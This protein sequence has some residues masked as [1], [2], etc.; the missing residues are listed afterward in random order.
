MQEIIKIDYP[1]K[2]SLKNLFDSYNCELNN[3]NSFVADYKRNVYE[4]FKSQ[5]F[6]TLKDEG[7]RY[8]NIS[9]LVNL[10]LSFPDYKTHDGDIYYQND[11]LNIDSYKIIFYNGKYL[12]RFSTIEELIK[13]NLIVFSSIAEELKNPSDEFKKYFASL[14]DNTRIFNSINSIFFEDGY[15]IKIKEGV[16][17]QKPILAIH[18][19]GNQNSPFI[20][21][22]RNIL[23]AENNSKADIIEASFNIDDSIV[24]ENNIVEYF[25]Y[26]GSE[27]NFI[28]LQQNNKESF[29]YSDLIAEINANAKFNGYVFTFGSQITRNEAELKL[30]GEYASG[31][32]YGLF[33]AKGK[34]II[35]NHTQMSHIKPNCESNQLYKG[36]LF[37][38][39]RG[40][41][42]GR[43]RVEK[44]AQ[45]TNAYQSNKNL[46]MSEFATINSKPQ[47]E[48]FADDV[49][50]T[51][52]ATVGQIDENAL[53]YLRTRGIDKENA[54]SMLILAFA[55]DA[56]ENLYN[57]NLKEQ[58]RTIIFRELSK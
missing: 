33:I 41:F 2:E 44:N 24:F 47:L 34:T 26:E 53:F 32:L 39:S 37:D 48:I 14:V 13:K 35:D 9:S 43:I 18:L 40:V 4:L 57:E 10:K 38:R 16:Q 6:P 22:I 21:P 29:H 30:N 28:K 17:L 50:C 56:I 7:W 52:G 11:Y 46:L 54:R 20:S 19:Y 23:I 36:I 31:H 8:T 58:L 55:N 51:H 5:T 15:F 27:I 3:L 12:K 42:R 45:K 25:G 49:K 1:V